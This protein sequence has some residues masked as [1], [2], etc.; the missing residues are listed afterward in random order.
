M[1]SPEQWIKDLDDG[2]SYGHMVVVNV[3]DITKIQLDALSLRQEKLDLVKL[4]LTKMA[5]HRLMQVAQ[6]ARE[7]LNKLKE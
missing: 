1:K 3:N 2:T 6:P 5:G 4:E 7:L